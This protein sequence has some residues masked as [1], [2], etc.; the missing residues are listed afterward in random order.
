[1]KKIEDLI[2]ELVIKAKKNNNMVAFSELS[3]LGNL[4]DDEFQKIVEILER[5]N[6]QLMVEQLEFRVE[7][8]V[9]DDIEKMLLKEISQTKLLTAEEERQLLTL[10]KSTNNPDAKQRLIE[11]NLK[12]V[13]SIARKYSNACKGVCVSF[14][15][16]FQDG[17]VGLDKAIE[18]FDITKGYRLSTYAVWWIKQAM[19]RSIADKG[20]TIRVPVYVKEKY[21]KI[22]DY[23]K[24]Y[25][26]MIGEEPTM[27]QCAEACGLSIEEVD[28]ILLS[29]QDTISLETP[30][31]TEGEERTHLMNLIPS[32]DVDFTETIVEEDF[33]QQLWD[34]VK[35]TLSEREIMII[36]SR[37]GKSG[38][39]Q[40]LEEIGKKL[41]ITRERVRQIEAKALI[42]LRRKVA[43]LVNETESSKVKKYN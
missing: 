30:V 38:K 20:S 13:A 32:G 43:K 11:S 42:K 7:G 12:L 5:E 19:S 9:D 4:P 16:L 37:M 14:L 2:E 23:K 34:L 41:G 33:N 28:N 24:Q 21:R 1:M 36:E 6:I 10:Y 17:T 26:S 29:V 22:Q 27:K 25:Y 39:V 40:Q 15:D 18:K 35:E 31:I 3:E 8:Y